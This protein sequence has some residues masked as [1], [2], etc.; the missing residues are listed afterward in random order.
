MRSQLAGN[1]Q[2][3]VGYQKPLCQVRNR[4]CDERQELGPRDGSDDTQLLGKFHSET[5][6][7]TLVIAVMVFQLRVVTGTPKSRSNV[8]TP[9]RRTTSATRFPPPPAPKLIPDRD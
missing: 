6:P 3:T 9:L 4:L 7:S 2:R 1:L 8:L 5:L